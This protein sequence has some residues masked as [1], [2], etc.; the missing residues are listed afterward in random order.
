MKLT[1]KEI[2]MQANTDI[3]GH[4]DI[5]IMRFCEAGFAKLAKI[6]GILIDVKM[7]GVILK[8]SVS[9]SSRPIYAEITGHLLISGG[10][11][12]LICTAEDTAVQ[13]CGSG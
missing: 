2:E 11:Q 5:T 9:F 4:D 7:L 13:S 1:D 3:R 10:F 8:H 12:L 6:E